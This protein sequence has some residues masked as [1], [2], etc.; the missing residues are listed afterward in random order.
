MNVKRCDTGFTLVELLIVSVLLA[1]LSSILYATLGGIMRSR[2]LVDSERDS[3]VAAQRILSRMSRE[4]NARV[5]TPLRQKDDAGGEAPATSTPTGSSFGGRRV[6]YLEGTNAKKSERNAD[7]IRFASASATQLLYGS[8][9]N[10][11]A[12]EIEY[13]L[14]ELPKNIRPETPEDGLQSLALVREEIPVEVREKETLDA[15]RVIFPLAEN[16]VGLNFRY[17]NEGK[18]QKDW[19]Q[20]NQLPEAVEI[21]LQLRGKEKEIEMFRTAIMLRRRQPRRGQRG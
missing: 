13:R 4:L 18:W 21:T 12:A 3:T 9:A 6:L 5:R 16:V 20:G 2:S 17:L 7:T 11:G 14:E 15:R 19:N 8:L 10:Q 1:L